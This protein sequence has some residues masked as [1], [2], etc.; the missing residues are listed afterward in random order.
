MSALGVLNDCFARYVRDL[1]SSIED[2]DVAL[3]GLAKIILN[4]HVEGEGQSKDQPHNS[5]H[6]EQKAYGALMLLRLFQE[7]KVPAP[8]TLRVIVDALLRGWAETNASVE[9]KVSRALLA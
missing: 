6:L 3:S 2:G 7:R 8:K 9:E 4:E 5:K 1:K